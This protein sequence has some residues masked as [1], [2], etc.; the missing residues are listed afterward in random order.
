MA[1]AFAFSR[2]LRA[3]FVGGVDSDV[4]FSTSSATTAY[5]HGVVCF[6]PGWWGWEGLLCE[7]GGVE[8]LYGGGE[9]FPCEGEGGKGGWRDIGD[10][11]F[12]EEGCELG[13]EG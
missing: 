10:A 5:G 2:V 13:V 1:L 8:A 11:A 9:T 12:G 6:G 3:G 7:R 4:N